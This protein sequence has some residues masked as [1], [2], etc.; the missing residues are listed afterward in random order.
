MFW[1]GEII[2]QKGDVEAVCGAGFRYHQLR[3]G[4]THSGLDFPISVISEKKI[5]LIPQTCLQA[6]VIWRYLSSEASS[7]SLH[8][9]KTKSVQCSCPSSHFLIYKYTSHSLSQVGHV[10]SDVASCIS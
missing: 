9:N 2:C 6:S 3:R 5:L 4:N 1:S 8:V 10:G 7:S